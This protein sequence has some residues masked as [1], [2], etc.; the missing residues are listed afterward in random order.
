MNKHARNKKIYKLY[1]Q[2]RMTFSEI[3]KKMNISISQIS[4]IIRKSENYTYEKDRR[5]AENRIKHV[6]ATKELI[7]KKRAT[8]TKKRKIDKDILDYLHNQASNELSRKR[9]INNQ[10]FRKWNS[11]IYEYYDKTKEYRLKDEF[12]NKTSYAIPKKIKWD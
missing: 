8:Q 4:R 10:A 1:F 7:K 3:S 9:N 5:K 2:N 6:Q 11:S 12:K